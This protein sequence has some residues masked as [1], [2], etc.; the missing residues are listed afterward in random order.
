M[1]AKYVF[2][3]IKFERNLDPKSSMNLGMDSKSYE[4]YEVSVR[5]ISNGG[6]DERS[7]FDLDEEETISLLKR[8]PIM[9]KRDFLN[10]SVK[11]LTDNGH[12]SSR[13]LYTTLSD[14]RE[15]RF[16]ENFEYFKYKDNYYPFDEVNENLNF[17]RGMEPKKSMGIG[18]RDMDAIQLIDFLENSGKFDKWKNH[19]AAE[20][21][22]YYIDIPLE[23]LY[24]KGINPT[25]IEDI[26]SNSEDR[27]RG[28]IYN[29]LDSYHISIWGKADEK[30][31]GPELKF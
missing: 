23:E 2:E 22:D 7:S 10:Y 6:G 5:T 30:Y 20:Y 29:D 12:T 13:N 25:I 14:L 1:K 28:G 21:D 27:G 8:I 18:L 16:V 4:I 15:R 9:N 26:T 17:E 11:Y 31:K 24:N 3:N 19:S